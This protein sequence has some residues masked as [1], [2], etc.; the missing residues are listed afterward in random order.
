MNLLTVRP[1]PVSRWLYSKTT[2]RVV[3]VS[4][5]L[6]LVTL[7]THTVLNALY[8]DAAPD[9][10]TISPALLPTFEPPSVPAWLGTVAAAQPASTWVLVG[11]VAAGQ[12]GYAL[13][14]KS[15]ERAR[16]VRIGQMLPD[17]TQLI[18]VERKS[19][20]LLQQG[21]QTTVSLASIPSLAGTNMAF[22]PSLPIL[23]TAAAVSMNVGDAAIQ[24]SITAAQVQ[25]QAAQ[26]ALQHQQ[27]Q[28]EQMMTMQVQAQ[29]GQA[30]AAT[31][32][33]MVT[34][35]NLLR[36]SMINRPIPAP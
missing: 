19:A 29:T 8:G 31:P 33:S 16:L 3:S 7:V 20:I 12:K 5:L 11:A 32:S 26:Q 36:P 34:P 4:L 10:S 14:Q 25:Q 9:T 28:Q 15:D 27:A 21:V 23:N 24:A 18:A 17:G 22:S 1:I 6:V 30:S 35:P 13:L 2:S